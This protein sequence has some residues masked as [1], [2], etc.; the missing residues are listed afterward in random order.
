MEITDPLCRAA[1]SMVQWPRA[2][3]A[4]TSEIAKSAIRAFETGDVDPGDE[5][6]AAL[7]QALEGAGAVFLDEDDLGIGVRLRFTRKDVK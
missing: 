7:R 4:A 6:K 3:L 2:Q 5:A 1:R